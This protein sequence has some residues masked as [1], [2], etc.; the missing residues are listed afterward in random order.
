MNAAIRTVPSRATQSR[1][2]DRGPAAVRAVADRAPVP[3][4]SNV[5]PC[6][7][8]RPSTIEFKDSTHVRI[9]EVFPFHEP[10]KNLSPLP[11]FAPVQLFEQE[12]TEETE[13]GFMVPMHK[14]TLVEATHEPSR[15]G[16]GKLVTGHLFGHLERNTAKRF[17]PQSPMTGGVAR[18]R[19][20]D[21]GAPR[22]TAP[23]HVQFGRASANPPESATRAQPAPRTRAPEPE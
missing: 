8:G 7:G 3:G 1:R 18:T 12:A 2:C 6:C 20:Q 5:A 23:I 16:A 13:N 10:S 15:T 4:R 17:L 9:L 11:L 14:R 21:A 19:R 22:F